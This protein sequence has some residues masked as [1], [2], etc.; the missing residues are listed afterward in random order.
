MK[1]NVT[2]KATD[3]LKKILNK[4]D[5]AGKSLRLYIAGFGWGGPSFGLAL[6]EQ[7]ETDIK[8]TIGDFE[9]VVDKDLTSQYDEFAIDY[10]NDWLRKGFSISANGSTGGC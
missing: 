9:F 2:E 4:K 3:E 6:D 8:N 10:V 1:I 5:T 7:K